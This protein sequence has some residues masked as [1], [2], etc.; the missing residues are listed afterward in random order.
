MVSIL[1]SLFLQ[2]SMREQIEAQPGMDQAAV[3]L[4]TTVLLVVGIVFGIIGVA[5]WILNAVFNAKGKKW[6]RILSTVLGGLAVVGALAGFLQPQPGLSM[7]LGVV[8]ALL[9][10]GIILL[11]WRPESSRFYEAA[12]APRY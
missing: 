7:T 9:A 12:S 8:Q 1:S 5:L 3:D 4:A 11:L 6:A 10:I 2:D